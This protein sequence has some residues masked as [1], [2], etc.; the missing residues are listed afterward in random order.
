MQHVHHPAH[1][2]APKTKSFLV[3]PAGSL[4]SKKNPFLPQTVKTVSRPAATA[5]GDNLPG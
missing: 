4:F 1:P 3:P 2:T 5:A